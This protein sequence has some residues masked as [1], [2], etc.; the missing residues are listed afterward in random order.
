METILAAS[1]R[2]GRRG[3]HVGRRYFFEEAT[4]QQTRFSGSDSGTESNLEQSKYASRLQKS[5][6]S[7]QSRCKQSKF[8]KIKT[9]LN[10]VTK[11]LIHQSELF[12]QP[13]IKDSRPISESYWCQSIAW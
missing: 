4:G 11:R 9:R 3:G 1:L 7:S 12:L 2:S 10:A 6:D 8:A 13:R 5:I